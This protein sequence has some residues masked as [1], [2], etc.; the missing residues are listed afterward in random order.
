[1]MLRRRPL[2]CRITAMLMA[3]AIY[4]Q[5]AWAAAPPVSPVVSRPIASI[6]YAPAS[7]ALPEA[8]PFARDN[9]SELP[10]DLVGAAS[11]DGSLAVEQTITNAA[12]DPI[13]ECVTPLGDGR[14]RAYFGYHNHNTVPVTIPVSLR[15][16]IF[17][18]P[19]DRGQPTTFQPGRSPGYPNAA[20]S[21]TFTWLPYIWAIEHS[22]H[23]RLA[24]ATLFSPRCAPQPAPAIT[25]TAPA[26][27]ALVPGPSVTVSGTIAGGTPPVAITVN[28]VTASR[29]GN[30]FTATLANVP[31]GPL[32][33]TVTARDLDERTAT[34]TRSVHV[35][36]APTITLSTPTTGTTVRSPIAVAGTV[37]GA[38]PVTVDVNGASATIA[39][40]AFTA[41]V[42]A[43]D[44]PLTIT[45]TARGPANS[46]AAATASVTVD[47]TPPQIVIVDPAQGQFT[48]A[49]LID[50]RGGVVDA[51][52]TTV[53]VAGAPATV[54]GSE[55]VA[56]GI[57]V[58]AGPTQVI[59]VQATDAAGN[60]STSSL[61]INV[62]RVAPVVAFT[63]PAANA[64]LRGPI[65]DVSGTVA[66]SS[67]VTVSINGEAMAVA[68]G[69]FTGQVPAADGS[70]VL[71]AEV[72]D[73]AG[74]QTIVEH[75]VVV[76]SVAPVI[77]I[78]EPA[79]DTITN[80]ASM[81]V[82][83]SVSDASITVVR[84]GSVEVTATGGVFEATLP[85]PSEGTNVLIV[86]ATDA[87]GNEAMASVN[88][89]SDRT[90]PVLAIT[91]PPA[92][93]VVAA[94]PVNIQGTVQ[95]LTGA[96][97]TVNGAAV[98]ING[99]TWETTVDSFAEGAATISV[100]AR[101]GAG[102]ETTASRAVTVDLTAPVVSIATPQ[103]GL[104]TAEGSVAVSG[105]VQ[106]VSV[107]QVLVNGV[108]ATLDPVQPG[109]Q[110]RA[111]S[112]TVPLNEGDTVI[113]ASATDGANRQGTAQVMVTRDA[114]PPAIALTVGPKV[115]RA[116]PAPA[117][118]IATDNL[119]LDRV[120][121]AVNG[122]IVRTFTAPP[123]VLDIAVPEGARPGDTLSIVAVAIDRVGN[124]AQSLASLPV[125]ADGAVVGQVLSDVTGRPIAAEASVSIDGGAQLVADQT[126]RYSFGTGEPR[127]SLTATA[128]N[129]TSV[130]R[131]FDVGSE[132][133][134]V[135]IDARLTP[136]APAATVGSAASTVSVAQNG[137][138][139][140]SSMS[141][142]VPGGAYAD[143]SSIRATAL[144]GQGLPGLLPL[145]WSPIAALDLRGPS[146]LSPIEL[147]VEGAGNQA[148]YL[149]R[150]LNRSWYLAS[151]A[152]TPVNG[153]VT[154]A[155]PSDEAIAVALVIPDSGDGAP[156]VPAIGDALPGVD[157]VTIPLTA[158][159]AGV[160]DPPVLSPSGGTSIGTLTVTSPTPLPSG[161]VVQAIVTETFTL[162]NGDTI[163]ED[164]RTQDFV[165]YR[166]ASGLVA[167]FPVVPS[168]SFEAASLAQGIV[169]LDILAGRESVRGEAG[170]SAALTLTT[171]GAT[172]GV[173]QGALTED[174]PITFQSSVLSSFLPVTG[175]IAPLLE[176]AVDFSG[177]TLAIGAELSVLASQIADLA[178]ADALVVVRVD[179]IEGLSRLVPVAIGE[180]SG[181]RYIARAGHG[182]PGITRG[183]RHVWYRVAGG[184]GFVRG[185]VS[186]NGSGLSALVDAAGLP[187]VSMSA[188]DGRFTAVTRPGN[189]TV[190]ARAL[191][192]SLAA[193]ATTAVTVNAESSVDLTLSGQ[194]TE[195]TIA[196]AAGA[197]NVSPAAQVEIVSAVSIAAQ[198]LAGATILFERTSDPAGAVPYRVVLSGSGR[199]LAIVPLTRLAEGAAYSVTVA[200]LADAVGGAITV[201]PTTFTTQSTASPEYDLDKLVF[202]F[203]NDE[204]QVILNGPAGTLPPGSTIL[205]VN[206]ST[207]EV[208][209]LGVNNDGSVS[210]VGGQLVAHIS[211]RLIV[212]ITD[213]LGRQT[214]FKRSEY[215]APD[216]TTAVG[217]GGGEVL[218]TGGVEVRIPEDAVMNGVA[219]IL[220]IAAISLDELPPGGL[221][222]LGLP[223]ATA[224]TAL[225]LES[226][227]PPSFNR[228]V[229]L[230]F[231]K[232]VDAPENAV[233]FVYRRLEGPD[234]RVAYETI[235]YADVEGEGD[236]AKVVTASFPMPGYVSSLNAYTLSGLD[237]GGAIGSQLTNYAIL[238]WAYE[239][240]S[241]GRVLGGVITGQ[242]RRVKWDPG[243]T[244]PTYEAV[245]GAMVSAAD[246]SGQPLFAT[247]PAGGQPPTVGVSQKGTGTYSLFDL[248]YTGG[249]VTVSAKLGGQTVTATAYQVDPQNTK[250][251]GLR[252]ARN[253][254]T[255]N[256]TF[257][258]VPPTLPPS[259]VLV[260][261]MTIDANGARKNSNGIVIAGE[262]LV[263]GV[264]AGGLTVQRIDVRHRTELT[265]FAARQDPL[266]GQSP[267]AFEAIAD[268]SVSLPVPG[269]Y[270][271]TATA[272]NP[273][274]GVVIGQIVVRAAAPGGGNNE[275]LPNEAPRVIT[276]RTYPKANAT[277]VPIGAL[278]QVA[279]TE[280]VRKVPGNVTLTTDDGN[281]IGILLSG[282]GPDGPV[283]DVSLGS[284]L[285]SLTVQ[286]SA[287]LLYGTHYTLRLTSGI[288]DID[289]GDNAELDKPLVEYSSSFTTF[290]PEPLGKTDE[291]FTAGGIT[292]IGERAYVA[293]PQA[294]GRYFTNLRLF[295]VSDPTTLQEIAYSEPTTSDM[296][297]SPPAFWLGMPVDVVSQQESVLTGGPVVAVAVNPLAYP[298]HTA[299]VRFFDVSSDRQWK[300]VG[301]VSL[302][303]EPTDGMIR[304][305][306]LHG[307]KLYAATAGVGKGIQVVDLGVMQG[308][309]AA[310][311]QVDR[312]AKYWEMQG[313]LNGSLGFAQEAITQSIYVDTNP[314]P[315]EG[316]PPPSTPPPPSNSLLWD[317]AVLDTAL[318]Q[319]VQPIV[320]ATGR[321][322]L[323]IADPQSGLV[324]YNGAIKDAQ[325]NALTSWGYG[326]AAGFVESLPIAVVSAL[327]PSGPNAGT[328]VL[329]VIDLTNPRVPRTLNVIPMKGSATSVQDVVLNGTTVLV[330]TN[331]G[332]Y[333]VSVAD[334]AFPKLI[335][336]IPKVSGRLA[337]GEGGLLF[338]SYRG[339]AQVTH[340]EEGGLKTAVL[341]RTTIIKRVTESPAVIAFD[342]ETIESQRLEYTVIPPDPTYTTGRLELMRN[343]DVFSTRDVALVDGAGESTYAA[344]LRLAPE[345]VRARLIVGEGEPD[346]PNPLARKLLG[347]RFEIHPADVTPLTAD[348]DPADVVATNRA[349]TR[350]IGEK[351]SPAY[352]P[353]SFT[354]R[355]TGGNG[356]ITPPSESAKS[357]I[358][359]SEI[360]P[361]TLAPGVRQ[362][363]LLFGNKLMARTA[364][365]QIVGGTPT[366]GTFVVAAPAGGN[367]VPA[368]GTS[369]VT[370]TLKDIEDQFGNRVPDGTEIEWTVLEGEDQGGG[371]EFP[372]TTVTNGQ[373]I[374]RYRAGTE[375]GEVTL[376]AGAEEL[377]LTTTIVQAR[378]SVT[379]TLEGNDLHA[380]VTSAAG[381]P[382][383]GTPIF[384]GT[385]KGKIV[386][387]K[388]LTD[389][390]SNAEF[391]APQD[392]PG[393]LPFRWAHV[394]AT[395]GRSR[396]EVRFEIQGPVTGSATRI[397]L[398]QEKL[399]GNTAP[400]SF[401][402]TAGDP[403]PP[404]RLP[405]ETL[406][407]V[408]GTPNAVVPVKIGTL[409][410]PNVEPVA[411][412]PFDTIDNESAEDIYGAS[413]ATVHESVRTDSSNPTF[414]PAVY[415]FDGN[416]GV[417]IAPATSN[418]KTDNFALNAW[419]RF[420]TIGSDQHVISKAGSYGLE[421]AIRDNLPRLVFYVMSGGERQ[422][423]LST[424]AM[425]AQTWYHV[426]AH[427]SSGRLQLVAN[428]GNDRDVIRFF[429]SPG[430]ADASDEPLLLGSSLV[431]SLD[432]VV[433]YDLSRPKLLTFADG[434]DL[435][436]VTL[437]ENGDATLPVM[438]TGALTSSTPAAFGLMAAA[439]GDQAPKGSERWD[440]FAQALRSGV[441]QV[442]EAPDLSA[443]TQTEK[444]EAALILEALTETTNECADAIASG[445]NETWGQTACDFFAG[446]IPGVGGYQ[447]GRDS[448]KTANNFIDGKQGI[449]DYLNAA[450]MLIKVGAAAFPGARSVLTGITSAANVV[451]SPVVRKFAAEE[452]LDQLQKQFADASTNPK[453]KTLFAALSDV[454]HAAHVSAVELTTKLKDNKKL[455]R[456]LSN[457]LEGMDGAAAKAFTDSLADI[458]R[459]RGDEVMKKVTQTFGVVDRRF[460]KEIADLPRLPADPAKMKAAMEGMATFFTVAPGVFP[461]TAVRRARRMW[462]HVK[463]GVG[464]DTA[465]QTEVFENLLTMI[466]EGAKKNIQDFDKFVK[467]GP[468][469]ISTSTAGFYHALQFVVR[470][471]PELGKKV[472][473][474]EARYVG[475]ERYIDA[476]LET[477]ER[478]ELKNILSNS[479]ELSE[480]FSRQLI[481]DLDEAVEEAARLGAPLA[482]VLE[483]FWYVVRIDDNKLAAIAANIRK[484]LIANGATPEEAAKV[485]IRRMG[486]PPFD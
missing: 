402:L 348:D 90:S 254:A 45:A 373:T 4:V 481:K 361:F 474:V 61:T 114:T 435:T 87:A 158:T 26:A 242:V 144:S 257:P 388:T 151:D 148:V 95:D 450:F 202:T 53:L 230:V 264:K 31:S 462:V 347:E 215:V 456:G 482:Q 37:G 311:T 68:D 233:F 113:V 429:D 98:P 289:G 195:A 225:K 423:V 306:R 201:P 328:H 477:G 335:A 312:G 244:S 85:L 439:Q 210:E 238:M 451:D 36:A 401:S 157:S 268:G 174:V 358:W 273:D 438:A 160:L 393:A 406:A 117:S 189:I 292:V 122:T 67:V 69:T 408:V 139:A 251:P 89:T 407:R 471:A 344:G 214:T 276:A 78:L 317:L 2:W 166:A 376:Q 267:A 255:A 366:Q 206:E 60:T 274:G 397:L 99:A 16:K 247:Q 159:S 48:N 395:V 187:F 467:K 320:V 367:A 102:N 430:P 322:P 23:I 339:L 56:G 356:A 212:T 70:T 283:A 176:F 94:L 131:V 298:Y 135:A 271:I 443:Q 193:E 454:N 218:G 103:S 237:T 313:A 300:W 5:S 349:L 459:T 432:E 307:D 12:I 427:F 6:A 457:A 130:D 126:G 140:T 387:E 15:N 418:S 342:G 460:A 46:T 323:V 183:G 416:G 479:I 485:V 127:V 219:A 473:R 282:V 79:A 305:I 213:P 39:N 196:P 319:V 270:T 434:S 252:F 229:D 235:D 141:L 211:D 465:K 27:N 333:L 54:S 246:A 101:D 217:N 63:T 179:Q 65:L 106:D 352:Q 136:I 468:G 74:N 105:T 341:E 275:S 399:A 232:P 394:F 412:Y 346:A 294:I 458:G 324:L 143:G 125:A 33:I 452:A 84:A 49:T 285:T 364:P 96:S 71:R 14:Y 198:S 59:E 483:R 301:A 413:T 41:S 281:E 326:V 258:A 280:P 150:Y 88:V 128:P 420:D 7:P 400:A 91:N 80:Q 10:R 1:M 265:E 369:W 185:E 38:S 19:I 441:L 475:S 424:Q 359:V 299:N 35:G 29:S 192:T 277:G 111:F 357:G 194:V 360:G 389:G 259:P 121:V 466:G 442:Y 425:A 227:D 266:A 436:S 170:G 9:S 245:E 403:P 28:G 417:S 256:L 228:E 314:A 374:V 422:E 24:L 203:P 278:V 248:T 22:G 43:P 153:V 21:E 123:F 293:T 182:L 66:D 303:R 453:L 97:V 398:D 155:L 73:A 414:A 351:R 34:A 188:T 132:T 55:F 119:V 118:L 404:P 142:V 108:A 243:A 205:V 171:T 58:G 115:T 284:V 476:V 338:G 297:K 261:V 167:T 391:I 92:G 355:L 263:I 370:V 172:L 469:T 161:T 272:I 104:L 137:A 81:L 231:P 396:G 315:P 371:P 377:G 350:R 204:G 100:V 220:K 86:T 362:V 253:V 318:D 168:R 226:P 50:I 191:G 316:T 337:L 181:D 40:G 331:A 327:G 133:G 262:P 77:T 83:G 411:A 216:G 165:L 334:P 3:A 353:P 239:L 177:R 240:A 426:S 447:T 291:K 304:R 340:P 444:S 169:H 384:F 124:T 222:D 175:E 129:M 190:R 478:I 260:S 286:P 288:T 209:S 184:V 455:L 236:N 62:D 279:F 51:T 134:T 178:P 107:S 164:A 368:D 379:V 445:E 42:T 76:D 415:R 431:G 93:T 433:L 147:R 162:T 8:A 224:S 410:N 145:G 381:L 437:D 109:S 116:R 207:G 110:A 383:D 47:S 234:G 156:A 241:P 336:E 249:T 378:L 486:T 464:A 440:Q 386:S 32:T 390:I 302:G 448:Y 25:I 310:A 345:D 75:T 421:L 332:T 372:I 30:G 296:L 120:T 343:G 325:N 309:F 287:G 446:L 64:V 330:G 385:S 112:A 295:D 138:L 13:L 221:P 146:P 329:A 375:P 269:S 380:E 363:E 321:K 52:A 18:P 199:T 419:V 461:G 470:G 44:G 392:K 149:A 208:S 152:L 154:V 449:F 405:G 409:R 484:V 197:I 163:S 17:L 11:A 20:F 180:L 365:L 308:V 82:R 463:N 480:V 472:V 223:E 382:A 428:S 290:V 57:A 72:R 250:S 200:G 354:W 173:A 186:A